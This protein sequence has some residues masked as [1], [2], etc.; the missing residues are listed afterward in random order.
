MNEQMNSHKDWESRVER[1]VCQ[2]YHQKCFHK[3][4]FSSEALSSASSKYLFITEVT[5]VGEGVWEA[6]RPI[7]VSV[8]DSAFEQ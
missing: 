5:W 1:D 3:K 2:L 4:T 7:K 6:V 8:L